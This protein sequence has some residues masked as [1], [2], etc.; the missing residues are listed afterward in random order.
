MEISEEVLDGIRELVTIGVGHS[1]GMLNDLTNAHVTLTVPEVHIYEITPET[2]LTVSNLGM[3]SDDTSQILLSFTGECSGSLSLIIP[4]KSAINLVILLTG[5][6]SSPDEMDALRVETLLEV[7]NIIISS[8]MSSFS[9]LLSS[10]LLFKFPS[11]YIGKGLIEGQMS[12][13]KPEIAILAKTQFEV[14]KKT[15]EGNILFLLTSSSFE[16]YRNSII[17]V[18]ERGL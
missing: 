13:T 5:E 16:R 18:M 9:I 3:I 17:H 7:G 1:A 6:D 4:H 12:K 14:Q 11:Y 10:R 8:V 15:I 2:M